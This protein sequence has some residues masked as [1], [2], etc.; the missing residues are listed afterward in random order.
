MDVP[1]PQYDAPA[2]STQDDEEVDGDVSASK[3][4][5]KSSKPNHEATSDEDED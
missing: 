5:K 2:K 3:R 1:R 4:R